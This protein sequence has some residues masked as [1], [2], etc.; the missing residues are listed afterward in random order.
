[1]GFVTSLRYTIAAMPLSN[2]KKWVLGIIAVS[3]MAAL[4]MA[5]AIYWMG[6]S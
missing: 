2:G 5:T 6:H 4:V 1:M 3:I